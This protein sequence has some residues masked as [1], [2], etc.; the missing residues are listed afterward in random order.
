MKMKFYFLK[1]KIY[2]QGIKM[3]YVPSQSDSEKGMRGCYKRLSLVTAQEHMQC[4][5]SGFL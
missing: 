1:T 5:N 2:Q 3:Y 4:L